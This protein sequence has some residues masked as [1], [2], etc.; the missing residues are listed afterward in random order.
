VIVQAGENKRVD[1][2]TRGALLGYNEHEWKIRAIPMQ[3]RVE[4]LVASLSLVFLTMSALMVLEWL[5]WSGTMDTLDILM[6]IFS[7]A[8]GALMGVA[9][10]KTVLNYRNPVAVPGLYEN[11]IQLPTDLVFVAYPEIGKV[12][13]EIG[14]RFTLKKRDVIRL[15]SKFAKKPGTPTDGW[16]ITAEF[17]GPGGMAALKERLEI[18]RGLKKARPSLVVFGPGGARSIERGMEPVKEGW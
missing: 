7:I 4:R 1:H 18:A 17:L 13:R 9:Y 10:F 2:V 14:T 12:E 6:T 16:V 3:A 5:F 8:A 11:G 15:R